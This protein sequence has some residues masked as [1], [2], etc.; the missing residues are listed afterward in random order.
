[1]CV[2]GNTLS[3]YDIHMK[4]KIGHGSICENNYDRISRLH[5]CFIAVA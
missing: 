4:I 5:R 2:C 1:M 3:Y